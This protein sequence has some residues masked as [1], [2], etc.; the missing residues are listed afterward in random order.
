MEIDNFIVECIRHYNSYD[1]ESFFIEYKRLKSV[2]KLLCKYER[3][4]ILNERL[5]LNHIIILYNLFDEFATY[6]LF[7]YID[8]AHWKYLSTIIIYLNRVPNK[9]P[10]GNK[11]FSDIGIDNTIVNKLREL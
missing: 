5:L 3:S 2:K 8:V 9:M 11:N 10:F 1:T 6:M 4:G 7:K